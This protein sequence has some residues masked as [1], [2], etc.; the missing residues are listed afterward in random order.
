MSHSQ[1]KYGYNLLKSK[2]QE[3]NLTSKDNLWSLTYQINQSGE[4]DYIKPLLYQLKL[5]DSLKKLSGI[6]SYYETLATSLSFIGDY[7]NTILEFQKSRDSLKKTK[8]DST[9][10]KS[11]ILVDPLPFIIEKAKKTSLVLIN[12]EHHKPQHRLFTTVLLKEMRQIGYKYLALEGLGNYDKIPE[13]KSINSNTGYYMLEPL[14]ADLAREALALGYKL[15][16]YEDTSRN[17]SNSILRDSAQASNIMS[18]FTKDPNAKILV[19]AGYGHIEENY[20]PPIMMGSFLKLKSGIDPLTIDQI[21]FGESSDNDF[22]NSIYNY[23]ESKFSP[24]Q[25]V[26]LTQNGQP[27]NINKK[28]MCDIHIIHPKVS[29]INERP[30]W[31]G[32]KNFR[33]PKSIKINLSKS[34]KLFLIQAYCINETLNNSIEK[35]IP[36]DQTFYTGKKNVVLYLKK[37]MN[38]KIIIRDINNNIISEQLLSF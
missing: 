34:K 32:Y 4:I 15:I 26:L 11:I 1:K 8:F 17:I 37:D 5:S 36:F 6:S 20:T 31:L 24:Q 12:E 3:L 23:L 2:S 22:T 10:Y 25:P 33:E 35:S 29:F 28:K 27:W 9:R 14:Y 13:I 16:P 38:Y 18:I 30:S 19:H 7:V 21:T